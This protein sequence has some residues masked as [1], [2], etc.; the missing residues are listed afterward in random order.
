VMDHRGT[1][2]AKP[3][4]GL[5]PTEYYE[6]RITDALEEA[7]TNR[8]LRAPTVPAAPKGVSQ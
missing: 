2:L 7:R 4:V 8:D 1:P 5:G 6:T 3:L